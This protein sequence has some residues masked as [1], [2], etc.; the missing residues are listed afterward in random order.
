[1]ITGI[2]ICVLELLHGVAELGF[3]KEEEGVPAGDVRVAVA[4]RFRR[5]VGEVDT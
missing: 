1:M 5:H 4:S 3:A 2:V